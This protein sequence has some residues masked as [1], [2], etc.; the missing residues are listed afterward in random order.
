MPIARGW[1]LPVVFKDGF[2]G[3]FLVDV[4]TV[5]DVV[6]GKFYNNSKL[7][8]DFHSQVNPDKAP[9]FTLTYA[10]GKAT[11]TF[12]HFDAFLAGLKFPF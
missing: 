5:Y 8:L 9:G 3:D 4:E 6:E 12:Q 7:T 1:K 2:D 11:P 10:Q